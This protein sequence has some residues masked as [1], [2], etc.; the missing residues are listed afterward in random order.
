MSEKCPKSVWWTMS[1]AAV[2]GKML[3]FS[4]IFA[5]L[6]SVSIWEPCPMHTH[7]KYFG[8]WLCLGRPCCLKT[9]SLWL[10]SANGSLYKI[11]RSTGSGSDNGLASS[12]SLQD[13]LNSWALNIENRCFRSKSSLTQT[14]LK[15]FQSLAAPCGW[16]LNR[17]RGRGWESRPISRFCFAL[18]LKRF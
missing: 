4:D 15:G 5:Y 14:N 17:G 11:T 9:A 8:L 1:K 16:E 6:V 7:Y 3:T 18:V 12:P 13:H 2:E 10:T